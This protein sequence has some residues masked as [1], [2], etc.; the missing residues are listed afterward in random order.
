MRKINILA[1]CSLLL[2][3]ACTKD[4]STQPNADNNRIVQVLTDNFNLTVMN[5]VIN[6]A[7]LAGDLNGS[8]PYTLFAPSDEAFAKAGYSSALS[9]LSASGALINSIGAYHTVEGNYDLNKLPFL[10]NQEITSKGGKLFITRWIKNND[11]IITIN[12]SRLLSNS[13]HASNGEV[14]VIDR[15]LQPYLH[16]N[17]ADAIA[18]E[19]TLTLFWQAVQRAGM[20]AQLKGT[21]PYTIY[22]PNNTAMAAMGYS[23]VEAINTASV[24]ELTALVK[25]QVV[26]DRRF[27]NDY[28][29]STAAGKTSTTQGMLDN[30]SITVNLTPDTQQPG[31]FSGITLKGI[32][33]TTNVTLVKQDIISGNG[34]LHITDKVLRITQ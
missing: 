11:T 25:Y 14:K 20:V 23:T 13:I 17:I 26:A 7:N 18:A 10:F 1:A 24:A 3:S 21:G 19:A 12:G 32:G 9:V 6:R 2:F 34:V 28:I 33:N 16:S 15:M 22:A 4:K 27:V 5:A 31:A 30:N 8:G 29:L